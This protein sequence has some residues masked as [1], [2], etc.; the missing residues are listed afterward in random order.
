MCGSIHSCVVLAQLCGT[1]NIDIMLTE[2]D[3]LLLT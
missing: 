3:V 2:E 1:V